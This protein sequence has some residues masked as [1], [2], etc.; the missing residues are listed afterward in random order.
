MP[1]LPELFEERIIAEGLAD[2]GDIEEGLFSEVENGGE[3]VLGA[4]ERLL[5]SKQPLKTESLVGVGESDQSSEKVE[6]VGQLAHI[7][8]VYDS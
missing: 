3:T 5:V 6:I 8:I 4:I 1:M 2:G 7:V